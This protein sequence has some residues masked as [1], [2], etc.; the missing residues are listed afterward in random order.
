M[1]KIPLPEHCTVYRPTDDGALIVAS[2]IASPVAKRF[3][4]GYSSEITR[5][6]ER[7]GE[8]GIGCRGAYGLRV[9]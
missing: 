5:S 8:L 3:D 7:D 1:K 2:V 6:G 9:E 4:N